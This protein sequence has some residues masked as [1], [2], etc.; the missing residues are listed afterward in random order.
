MS[1]AAWRFTTLTAVS[2]KRRADGRPVTTR[3]QQPPVTTRQRLRRALKWLLVVVLVGALLGAASFVVL[4]Q[5]IDVPD[6]NEDFETQTSFVYYADGRSELGRFA[7]Q[8]RDSI[9]LDEMPDTIKDAVI[10]A[11]NRSFYTDQGIDPK[12]IVRAAF[13][14]ASGGATQGAS[15]ITQQYVK[16]LYLTS[17]R[18]LQRKMTEA[19]LSLKIQREVSKEE[20]LEGYLNTIYFGRG[21]YGIQAAAQAFFD[22]PAAKLGLR[23]SAVLASVL[24]NPSNLDPANGKEA[25]DALRVRYAY[26]LHGMAEMG[27]ISEGQ[28]EQAA[29]RLPRFPEIEAESQL[30]G[31]R[32]HMLTLVRDELKRLEFTDAQIDGDGLRV[33]TTF[34]ASAMRAAEDGVLAQRPEGFGDKQLHI[35]AALVEPGSGAVRGFYG[36]QDFLDSQ[37][38]WAATGGMAGS[39]IKP[40]TVAAAIK[41]GFSLNDSFEGNSPYEFPDGL[42]VNNEGSG[43]DGLGNDYGSGVSL[44]TATEQSINTAFVDMTAGMDDGPEAIYDMARALGVPGDKPSNKYPGIPMRSVDFMPDDTLITLGRGRVSPINMANAYATIANGGERA[45]AHVIEKV[46][47]KDG[48]VLYNRGD[49]TRPAVEEDI[50]ADASYAMQQVV[51]SGTGQAALAL[52]R[53]AAGKTGTATAPSSSGDEDFVSSAWFAGYTPQLA[54]AVMY[55]RGDGDDQ[56]D[57]WLPSYFGADYPADTWTAIM[58]QATEGMEVEDFPEPAYVDGEAPSDG[59]EYVP[60]PPPPSPTRVP[61]PPPKPSDKPTRTPDPAPTPT[62]TPPPPTLPPPPPPPP[63]PPPPPPAP[64]TVPPPPPVPPPTAPPT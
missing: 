31:Q 34:T 35:G 32:G 52:G 10:A 11:E 23:E 28:A 53:P 25:K 55:V 8:N 39:T 51:Q 54:A 17:E 22:K 38:N 33:T 15:T 43:T 62:P 61:P 60:P 29:R 44:V 42:T 50:A 6:P 18:S 12:G 14:N 63:T 40:L 5:T 26:A 49:R 20:I 19:I 41:Q 3:P 13:S 47:G 57:G 46:V 30:G 58:Q 64:P 45:D 56:L 27:K 1:G 16:I 59:Y 7:N 48:E 24:N 9:P 4:Y 37:I 36:G 2:A 21:A